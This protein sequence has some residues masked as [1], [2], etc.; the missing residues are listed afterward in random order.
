MFRWAV[1]K[2]HIPPTVYHA[3]QAVQG[4][5]RGRTEAHEPPPIEPSPPEDIDAALPHLSPTIGARGQVRRLTGCRPGEVSRMTAPE[6]DGSGPAWI[7]SP[8]HHK[9]AWRGKKRVIAIGPKAQAVLNPFLE[10]AAD[11]S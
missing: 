1:S 7:Y 6:T 4:L 2:E 3:L 9:T 8:T 5:Q 10:A 11:G